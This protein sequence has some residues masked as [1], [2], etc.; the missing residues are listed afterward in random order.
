MA[1]AGAMGSLTDG[2][3][4]LVYDDQVLEMDSAHACTAV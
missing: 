2:C 3:R 1:R 4:V